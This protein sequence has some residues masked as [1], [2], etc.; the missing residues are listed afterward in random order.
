M[1]IM[2]KKKILT[3]KSFLVTILVIIR[4]LDSDLINDNSRN[5]KT[6]EYDDSKNKNKID[7]ENSKQTQN[8]QTKE[9]K[10]PSKS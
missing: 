7:G 6:S 5:K 3:L 4:I 9:N 1:S 2:N 10:N 8:T